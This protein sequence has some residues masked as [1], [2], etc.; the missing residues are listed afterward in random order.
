MAQTIVETPATAAQP[1]ATARPVRKSRDRGLVILAL[2]AVIWYFLFTIGPLLAMFVLGFTNWRGL[3]AKFHFNGTANWTKLFH[4]DRIL[5]ALK[6][7]AIHMVG[8]LPV[9]LVGSFMIGYFLNLKLPGHRVF[10][11]IMFIPALISLSVLG[12][13]FVAVLGPTGLVNSALQEFHLAEGT[14]WL[15]DPRTAMACIIGITI[16]SGLGFTSILFAARLS[17]IDESIY[18]AAEIDGAS[19]WQRMWLIAFPMCREYF[20]VV[21]MLQFLWN[22][23]G[24]AGLIL[25]LTRGGPGQ[26]TST[27]SWLIYDFGFRKPQV[28]YS[29]TVGLV[30]FVI[31]VVGLVAIRR[32]FRARY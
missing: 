6:N 31:G 32:A 18:D 24:S 14:A 11:V 2:P 13:L 15:A 17:A 19:H 3:N 23:F 12:M 10:R 9:M 25:I 22:L 5:T 1:P 20:G 28:G 4:D 8:S 29:Q 21:T 27:M 26:A 16:W 30:L 7:T